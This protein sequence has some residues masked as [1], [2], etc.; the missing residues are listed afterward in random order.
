VGNLV[1]RENAQCEKVGLF[2]N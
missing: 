2:K 1:I